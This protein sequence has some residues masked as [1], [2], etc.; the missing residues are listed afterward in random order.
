MQA[1]FYAC[2]DL[3]ADEDFALFPGVPLIRKRGSLLTK[4][5][6][7]LHSIFETRNDPSSL[8]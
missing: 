3:E 1:A 4:E 2:V 5:S 7:E 8:G 6:C